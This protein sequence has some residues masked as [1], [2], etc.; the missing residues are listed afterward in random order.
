VAQLA[1]IFAR[2]WV[3]P[4][5][6]LFSGKFEQDSVEIQNQVSQ[7]GAEAKQIT[8]NTDFYDLLE[9]KSLKLQNRASEIVTHI[10]FDE[11]NSNETLLQAIE[12]Y[13]EKHGNVGGGR[14]SRGFLGRQ[15]TKGF[16]LLRWEIQSLC[17]KFCCFQRL[18]TVFDLVHSTSNF[19]TNTELLTIT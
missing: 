5:Q 1:C 12:Y 14:S 19:P 13:T 18:R 15:R 8:K 10:Q 7:L 16:D 3:V 6:A 9:S 17:I 4:L 2:I 11:Q